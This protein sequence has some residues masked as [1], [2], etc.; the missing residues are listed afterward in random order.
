MP[1]RAFFRVGAV[2]AVSLLREIHFHLLFL[3]HSHTAAAA[4]GNMSGLE[5][6]LVRSFPAS[7]GGHTT[8]YRVTRSTVVSLSSPFLLPLTAT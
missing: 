8:Y 4:A 1:V 3:S 2:A 6:F 7:H 5:A